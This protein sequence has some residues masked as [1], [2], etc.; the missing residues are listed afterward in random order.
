MPK[1]A[2]KPAPAAPAPAAP[3]PEKGKVDWDARKTVLASHHVPKV[4]QGDTV[5]VTKFEIA[6]FDNHEPKLYMRTWK[7]SPKWKGP[8]SEGG[9]WTY[10]Q[11]Q[12]L[13]TALER[14]VEIWDKLPTKKE[15]RR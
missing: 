15:G 13:I 3:A 12:E 8:T 10:E 1:P 11:L 5:L 2:R 7:D 14:C 4:E 6:S 9:S